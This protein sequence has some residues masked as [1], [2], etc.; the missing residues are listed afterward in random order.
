M[1][2]ALTAF[3]TGPV[4]KAVGLRSAPATVAITAFNT[5]PAVTLVAPL[6]RS[7]YTVG[8][9]IPLQANASDAEDGSSVTRQWAIH[10]LHSNQLVQNVFAYTGPSPPNFVVPNVGVPGDRI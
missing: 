4:A 10:R 3:L 1:V 5:A 7:T 8:Q 6:H 9:S 2:V